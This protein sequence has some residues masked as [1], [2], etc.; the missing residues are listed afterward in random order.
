MFTVHVAFASQLN[1]CTSSSEIP[2]SYSRFVITN[3]TIS[4][5]KLIIE[6]LYML[7]FDTRVNES[8]RNYAINQALKQ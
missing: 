8:M 4:K 7:D 1:N 6:L 5:S 3:T 2:M